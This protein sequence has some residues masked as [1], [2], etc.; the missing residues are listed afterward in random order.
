MKY[1]IANLFN[2]FNFSIISL[3]IF[4]SIDNGLYWFI[5]L[6]KFPIDLQKFAFYSMFIGLIISEF[7]FIRDIFKHNIKSNKKSYITYF[8][9]VFLFQILIN[10]I[11]ALILIQV[12]F[13]YYLLV[14]IATINSITYMIG[15]ISFIYLFILLYR[16][17][18][19]HI[20]KITISFA[21]GA[22]SLTIFSFFSAIIITIES[23]IK[24][25]VMTANMEEM[26]PLLYQ[27][28]P[29]LSIGVD[30]FYNSLTIGTIMF[31]I[32][33]T[34]ISLNYKKRFGNRFFWFLIFLP[35]IP[36][37]LFAVVIYPGFYPDLYDNPLILFPVSINQTMLGILFILSFYLNSREITFS[38]ELKNFLIVSGL[39]LLLFSISTQSDTLI[40]IFPPFGLMSVSV[41]GMS[42]FLIFY[43]ISNSI[44]LISRDS[45]IRKTLRNS[46]SN[47]LSFW[48]NLSSPELYAKL[49]TT[50]Y[51][52]IQKHRT[53][54]TENNIDD[55]K[56]EL[57][58]YIDY[59]V[60]Y[61]EEIKDNNKLENT[62]I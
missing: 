15:G 60:K 34:F 58:Y 17:L 51:E 59:L 38:K 20:S 45:N 53:Q 61:K 16:S 19:Y 7:F 44:Q 28:Y 27:I 12:A 1:L 24:T 48:E 50:V 21:L 22:L 25:P 40:S 37:T 14:E 5:E 52:I 32:G 26:K 31:W 55:T 10:F 41:I 42:S 43:G 8:Y 49:N 30:I 35:S 4:V 36:L 9:L 18:K 39:G 13:N 57:K 29:S 3:I 47:N 11:I 54:K 2:K 56:N 6:Y 23:L 46:L 33:T 62:D